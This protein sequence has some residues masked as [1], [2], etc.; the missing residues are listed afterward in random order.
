MSAP[1]CVD[2]V[3]AIINAFIVGLREVFD[4]ASDCPP[5]GGGWA[6][7]DTAVKFFAGDAIPLAAWD[8]HVSGV[9]CESPFLW[10]RLASRYFTSRHLR[11]G[12]SFP[13]AGIDAN[14]CGTD[15][16]VSIELGVGRCALMEAETAWQEYAHQAEIS[17]DDSWRIQ[18]AQC[19][20]SGILGFT[21]YTVGLD[22][23]TPYG[24]E[25]GVIAWTG[26]AHV[27]Y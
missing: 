5:D 2:P 6:D 1:V 23:V 15:N 7:A 17:L 14:R 19:R 25:G 27:Q 9:G 24:P 26:L 22:T 21:D 16:A 4:P 20:A 11:T 8:S 13:V 18:L 12:Q 10:V 3:S